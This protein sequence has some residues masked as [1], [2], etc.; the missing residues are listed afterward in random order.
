MIDETEISAPGGDKVAD[1][2]D[3]D[4]SG[5]VHLDWD[6]DIPL[7]IEKTVGALGNT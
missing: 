7:A 6:R 4:S 2:L 3:L 1:R 5:L